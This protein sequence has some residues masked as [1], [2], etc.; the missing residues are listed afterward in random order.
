MREEELFAWSLFAG[1]DRFTKT[2]H[3]TPF[4]SYYHIL[5]MTAFIF[6]IF[7]SHHVKKCKHARRGFIIAIIAQVDANTA[8]IQVVIIL[9][10]HHQRTSQ[11]SFLRVLYK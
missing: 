5:F 1:H 8:I 4:S 9:Q 3:S 10:S 6:Y 7:S 2:F 11:A